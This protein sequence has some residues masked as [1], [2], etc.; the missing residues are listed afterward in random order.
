MDTARIGELVAHKSALWSPDVDKFKVKGAESLEDALQKHRKPEYDW[1]KMY[2]TVKADNATLDRKTAI[3]FRWLA[4]FGTKF[5]YSD[6][7]VVKDIVE[8]I[9]SL[10]R[11]GELRRAREEEQGGSEE[12]A[13][14]RRKGL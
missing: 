2:A 7:P 13:P 6:S 9:K 1:N 14:K 4:I 8:A 10:W 12:P 3:G 11:V 5:G